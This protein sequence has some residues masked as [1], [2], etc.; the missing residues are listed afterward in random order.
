MLKKYSALSVWSL[1]LIGSFAGAANKNYSCSGYDRDAGRVK[2]SYS[3]NQKGSILKFS[4]VQ[5]PQSGA[6]GLKP[7]L[8]IFSDW[9]GA[10]TIDGVRGHDCTRSEELMLAGYGSEMTLL[11]NFS[12]GQGGQVDVDAECWPSRAP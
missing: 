9:N 5:R 11:Y 7:G 6:R 2:F 10:V 8:V 12:C 4:S 1:L 3:I